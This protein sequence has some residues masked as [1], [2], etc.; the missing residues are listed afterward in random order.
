MAN[1]LNLLELCIKWPHNRTTQ[2]K[3]SD[4]GFMLLDKNL[5]NRILKMVVEALRWAMEH[6]DAALGLRWENYGP[7]RPPAGREVSSQALSTLIGEKL[8]A[9]AEIGDWVSFSQ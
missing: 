2:A 4:G 1:P 3:G 8:H 7:E 6:R 9:D 5:P